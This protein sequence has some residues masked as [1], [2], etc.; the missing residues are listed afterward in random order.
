MSNTTVESPRWPGV[1]DDPET[2]ANTNTSSDEDD[3]ELLGAP[4]EKVELPSNSGFELF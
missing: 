2:D 3:A 4:V 1:E